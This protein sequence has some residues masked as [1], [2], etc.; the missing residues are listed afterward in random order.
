MG[1]GA[2]RPGGADDGFD[3]LLTPTMAALPAPIGA[4]QGEDVDGALLGALPYAVFTAPFN[5]TG[6]PAMSVPATWSATGLPI[7]VQLVAA[8]GR[9]DLLLRVA[10]QLEAAPLGRSPPALARVATGRSA[11]ARRRSPSPRRD[12][13]DRARTLRA[14]VA[15]HADAGDVRRL[16]RR[17]P[18][19]CVRDLL[20]LAEPLEVETLTC[21][22]TPPGCASR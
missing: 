14:D 20:R 6:Q 19:H 9:E 11:A 10:S 21:L 17:E 8:T 1:L 12:R 5:M 16:V 13:S 3:L 2:S 7:G 22:G 18:Q 4:V 15:A